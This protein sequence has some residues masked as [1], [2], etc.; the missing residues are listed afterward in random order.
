METPTFAPAALGS[1]RLV[2][3]SSAPLARAVAN[4]VDSVMLP[5]M[6][7]LPAHLA[8]HR[9][10]RPALVVAPLVAEE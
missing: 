8:G 3:V 7:V 5:P 6:L 4:V 9:S 2:H 10:P 1:Q